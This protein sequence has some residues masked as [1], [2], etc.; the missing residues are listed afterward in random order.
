MPVAAPPGVYFAT[1]RHP[2]TLTEARTQLRYVVKQN[3][4]TTIQLRKLNNRWELLL[5]CW[6][7]Q[8]AINNIDITHASNLNEVRSS[9]AI[10]IFIG[11]SQFDGGPAVMLT[12]PENG[13]HRLF[14]GSND[15]TLQIHRRSYADRWICRLVLPDAW[16]V[17]ET[18]GRIKI[19]FARTHSNSKMIE[20]GPNTTV[21]WQLDPGRVEID[22]SQWNDLPI[23]PVSPYPVPIPD[24]NKT[25]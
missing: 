21:P 14:A 12:V 20:L 7:I 8:E 17:G 11:P 16:I 9:E 5:E 13:W 1:L 6:R 22:I 2:L 10:T 18:P 4:K 24:Y 15:G 25:G 19:G 3:Q 23:E